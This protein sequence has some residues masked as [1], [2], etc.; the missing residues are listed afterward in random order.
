M[1]NNRTNLKQDFPQWR[2]CNK[3]FDNIMQIFIYASVIFTMIIVLGLVAFIFVNG[4]EYL[5][6]SF[7]TNDYDDKTI[8]ADF[9]FG[10]ESQKNL[11]ELEE[12]GKGYRIVNMNAPALDRGYDS[13]GAPYS[14]GVGDTLY[15]ID[16][17]DTKDMSPDEV[18]EIFEGLVGVH[19]IRA[20]IVG[21]GIYPMIISTL[22]V[23]FLTLLFSVPIGVACAVYLNEY[24]R[25]GRLLVMIRF[26]IECLAGIPS[27]IYGLFGMM[28]FVTMLRMNYSVLAGTLT[29]AIILLPT[30]IS[31]SEEALKTIPRGLREASFALGASQ[32]QTV[33]RVVLPNAIPGILTSIV[34][35]IG[36]II[37][38]SAALILTA[39][40]VA[41]IP[42]SFMES[43]ST[44]TVK[45][46][47]VTKE[48]GD[49]GMAC[50]MGIVIILTILLLNILTRSLQKLRRIK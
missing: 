1:K 29:V 24:A 37:G 48:E 40:T 42:S 7:F 36:R 28:F 34:L 31:T 5:S 12:D 4:Y 27:I 8:Y 17:M 21:G 19:N 20:T 26:A 33:S 14:L 50:A 38:E 30:I 2:K 3:R 49:I 18:T 35:S 22:M 23:I 13:T 46:Y 11:F 45:V 47:A 16:R 10:D 44:I 41:R 15:T 9:D 32:F 25:E 43:A 6:P 39:G